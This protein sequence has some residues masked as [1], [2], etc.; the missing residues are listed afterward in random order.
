MEDQRRG[1]KRCPH[2]FRE[3]SENTVTCLRSECQEAEY[4]ANRE[5]NATAKKRR[6]RS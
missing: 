4:I 2:C 6:K 1:H 5:R 3:L